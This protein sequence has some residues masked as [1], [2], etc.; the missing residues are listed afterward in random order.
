MSNYHIIIF[1]FFMCITPLFSMHQY[2]EPQ[3][4]TAN[5]YIIAIHYPKPEMSHNDYKYSALGI[6]DPEEIEEITEYKWCPNAYNNREDNKIRCCWSS[7]S[8]L[9]TCFSTTCKLCVMY[10]T[11]CS[12][13][14]ARESNIGCCWSWP[15]PCTPTYTC[16]D[17][18]WPDTCDGEYKITC[19]LCK[20]TSDSWDSQFNQSG[21]ACPRL[22]TIITIASTLSAIGAWA[23]CH[24]GNECCKLRKKIVKKVFRRKRSIK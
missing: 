5:D 13:L 14:C 24:N 17:V 4:I 15:R 3:L 22:W 6:L 10:D 11:Y 20:D 9:V 7:V 1:A 23:P 18:W 19:S 16:H 8:G 2:N 12:N 21:P